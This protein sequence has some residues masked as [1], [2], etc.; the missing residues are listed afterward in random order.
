MNVIGWLLIGVGVLQLAGLLFALLQELLWPVSDGRY[1]G[2]RM[3][4]RS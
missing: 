2:E 4:F 1:E 3:W